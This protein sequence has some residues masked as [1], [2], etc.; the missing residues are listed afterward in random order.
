M[1][2]A[3]SVVLTVVGPDFPITYRRRVNGSRLISGPRP[4]PAPHADSQGVAER[5][6]TIEGA[7]IEPLDGGRGN[8]TSKEPGL[9]DELVDASRVNPLGEVRE[10]MS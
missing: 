5:D 6:A 10:E 1:G 2:E 7:K 8:A 4:V 9:D 3:G